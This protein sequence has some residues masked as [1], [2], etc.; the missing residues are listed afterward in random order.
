MRSGH[1]L[2][3][4]HAVAVVFLLIAGTPGFAQNS[5][6][7]GA[8]LIRGFKARDYQGSP[9]GARVLQHPQTGAMLYLAGTV[10]HE[11]D[12]EHW[13]GVQT[14][15][16]AIRSL[17][18]D[19][20]GR[21]W[22]GGVDQLG[23]CERDARGEW[24][25]QPLADRV[26]EEHRKIGRIWDTVAM[27]DTI[28]FAT[29]NKVYRWEND[30]FTVWTFP[31]I[32]A[33]LPV[34]QELYFHQKNDS[35]QKWDGAAFRVV[36]RD[37]LVAGA[38]VSRLFAQ[39]DGTIHGMTSAGVF[40]RLRGDHVEPH[41]ANIGA[42]LGKARILSALPRGKGGWYLGTE[43]GILVVD[44][45]GQLVQAISKA[46]GLTDSPVMDLTRDRS[47]A[48]WAATF[49]GLFQIEQ[50]EAVSIFSEAQGVPEGLSH[51]LKRHAGRLYF[52]ATTGLLQLVPGKTAGA[53]KFEPVLGTPRYPQ[54][55]LVHSTGLLLATSSGLLRL[56][57]GELKPLIAQKT[58]LVSLATS[59]LDPRVVIVGQS[60]GAA[61]HVLEK[62]GARELRQFPDLGQIRIIHEDATGAMWLSTSTRGVHRL[63][64]GSGENPWSDVTVTTF[65]T[66]NGK[67]PADGNSIIGM[68]SPLGLTF[69]ATVI[70][71]LRYDA[72]SD[73]F[74]R[75]E[76]F[77]L[78]GAPVYSVNLLSSPVNPR[79]TW[80]SFAAT[81]ENEGA[82]FGRLEIK[83]DHA[84]ITPASIPLLDVLGPIGAAQTWTEGTGA[85]RVVWVAHPEG[86]VRF[87][88][89]ALSAPVKNWATE[90]TQFAANDA[91]QPLVSNE[92]RAFRYSRHPYVVSFRAPRMDRGANVRYQTRLVGWDAA[93]SA[94]S[95]VREARFSGLPAGRYHFEVRA[96]DRV[97]NHSSVATLAFVVTP[98]LW[99][100]GWAIAGYAI[101]TLLLLYGIIRLRLRQVNAENRYLERIVA[102]RTRDLSVAR[103]QAEAANRAKSSFL[104]HMSHEL[105][106]PLN[107][108]IGY[109]QVLLRDRTL[110]NTHRSRVDIVHN[111]GTHLLRLINEVLDFSK[112]EAGKVE[113]HDTTF[114]PGQLLRELSVGHE[115]AAT[116]RGLE[117]AMKISAALPEFVTSDPQKLRQV[118]DNLL[119]N[120]IK[121]TRAGRVELSVSAA[122]SES[123]T[124]RVSDTGAGL[125]KEELAKLFAPFSQVHAP[126]N[127]D[128]G[129]GLGL[130]I[131][132]RIVT[133]LGGELSV[134]SESGHGSR[135]SFTLTLPA[136][137]SPVLG[138]RV[139]APVTGYDGAPRRVFIVD[140]HPVNRTLLVDLLTPLGFTCEAHAS[141]EDAL[142]AIESSPPPDIALLD[143]KLPGI[144]GL[145]LTRRL[146][147]ISKAARI[148]IVL[149]SA[150][151]LTFDATAA[152]D[153]GANDFLPKPFAEAQLHALLA[154]L[155]GL[156]WK[157]G[158][159]ET[160]TT[161]TA[162][163]LDTDLAKSLLALADAGDVTALRTAI[164]AA[165][166]QQPDAASFLDQLEELAA[167]YQLERVRQLLRA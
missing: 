113:R 164:T 121:F 40:F 151:V 22:L 35:L 90:I 54:Q 18:V 146:R 23:Y 79:E 88:P 63:Q 20:K 16:P 77:R 72:A 111:S 98:P 73:R 46:D 112:I 92:K 34:G 148:P 114:Q 68:D 1:P 165:R 55:M 137:K 75:D 66:A 144:D 91:T 10:L 49:S 160:T 76:R 5:L 139:I 101:A 26:P 149:T 122:G 39:A 135:F 25:F 166:T 47:G 38:S 45:A 97:G 80:G 9:V 134:E 50:P 132:Q 69:Q 33:L 24:H 57:N 81:K 61:I 140:D 161:N 12:G 95:T 136:V 133:L 17:A 116:S 152:T 13:T 70:G 85:T 37:P 138:D 102:D 41:L 31:Q 147:K 44:G 142:A 86:I 59:K 28:W 71:Q 65:D 29:D 21:V 67:L 3:F 14:G 145:E 110:P 155:L 156:T 4:S 130:V 107:G 128:A 7:T 58:P 83:G 123:W 99:L 103:D 143:L 8:P 120:A 60:A 27:G 6:E 158:T 167:S 43:S 105:R 87:E 93:W 153:A 96:V 129:T 118:L 150:S 109:A 42:A 115:A 94:P 56:E 163:S 104:A 11:F 82:I 100:S 62:N 84:E 53:A 119:S 162:R 108:I 48:V 36:S 64:A 32:G 157:R 127:G 74:V 141:A 106:T 51:G 124:F 125:S 154:S 19:T 126:V 131:T 117:F 2:S 89:A 30:T 78:N 52:S 159:P 15:V